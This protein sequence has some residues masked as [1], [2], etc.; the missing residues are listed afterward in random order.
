MLSQGDSTGH[1]EI[2]YENVG[3]AFRYSVGRGLATS[4]C[5]LCNQPYYGGR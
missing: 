5:Q 3:D 4:S 2:V 1:N